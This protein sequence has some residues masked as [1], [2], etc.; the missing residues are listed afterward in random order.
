MCACAGYDSKEQHICDDLT[1][2]HKY[3]NQ[4][5]RVVRM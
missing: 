5:K 4:R 3:V 2:M 1:A